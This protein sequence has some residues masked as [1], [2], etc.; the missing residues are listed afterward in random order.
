MSEHQD[1][2]LDT[3]LR[4]R[5]LEP[6]RPNLAQRIILKAERIRQTQKILLT[7]RGVLSLHKPNRVTGENTSEEDTCRH[8]DTC[9]CLFRDTCRHDAPLLRLD[10][11]LFF[12]G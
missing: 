4:Y 2:K 5:R 6:A 10:L 12:F 11:L 3:M 1:E 8:C 9:R 7:G